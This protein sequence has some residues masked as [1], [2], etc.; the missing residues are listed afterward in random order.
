METPEDSSLILSEVLKTLQEAGVTAR[1]E[2]QQSVAGHVP[3][4]IIETAKSQGSDLIIMGS[5]GL[6]NLA[7]LL[8]GSVTHNVIQL[9]HKPVLVVRT[10]E[11]EK[12]PS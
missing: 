6:S 1:G 5:R 2:V 9:A 11:V 10:A 12:D 8:L 4:H 7:G 3:K